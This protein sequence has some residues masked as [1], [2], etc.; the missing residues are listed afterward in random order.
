MTA[1]PNKK[2]PAN[3]KARSTKKPA[4]KRGKKPVRLKPKSSSVDI[5]VL[6]GV[7]FPIIGA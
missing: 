1:P 6:S 2:R 5:A 7:I 4:K 3:K